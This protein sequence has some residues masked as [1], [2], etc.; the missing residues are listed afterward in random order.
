MWCIPE[1]RRPDS[2]AGF[3]PGSW[4]VSLAL[5]ALVAGCGFR[6]LHERGTA[7]GPAVLAAVEIENIAD[8]QGQKLRNFLL[9]RLNPRGAPRRPLYVLTIGLS[10]SK[11]GLGVRKDAFATRA[12]LTVTATFSLALAR[13]GPEDG[14][15]FGGSTSSTNFYNIVQSEFATLAAEEDAR[16]RAL[17][18]IADEIRLRIAAGLRAPNP[19][20]IP[21][22][23]DE[24]RAGQ[25]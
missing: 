6:P 13:A 3:R 20:R 8:R 7:G 22:E 16:D 5:V 1:L 25:N 24:D 17:L 18:A 14:G 19:F 21:E 2:P 23:T 15:R 12:F 11:G 9:D 10:E 4:L